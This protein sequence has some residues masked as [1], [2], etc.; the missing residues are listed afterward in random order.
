MAPDWPTYD[1]LV[2]HFSGGIRGI[3]HF[4]DNHLYFLPVIRK[5][6]RPQQSLERFSDI[7]HLPGYGTI[8]G[9]DFYITIDQIQNLYPPIWESFSYNHGNGFL[10]HSI[11]KK[12]SDIQNAA[13]RKEMYSFYDT[14]DKISAWTDATARSLRSASEGYNKVLTTVCAK[15][16]FMQDKAFEDMNYDLIIDSL[17]SFLYHAGTLRDHI[18]E[19]IVLHIGHGFDRDT[20]KKP[21]M[22]KLISQLEKNNSD[23]GIGN[24]KQY[25]LDSNNI[26][27]KAEI[28]PGW[29][30][31]LS[32]YRNIITHEKSLDKIVCRN[33]MWMRLRQTELWEIPIIHFPIPSIPIV[34]CDYFKNSPNIPF[35]KL[36]RVGASH[37]FMLNNPDGLEVMW[38]IFIQLLLLIEKVLQQSPLPPEPIR[39]D[40]TNSRVIKVT[41]T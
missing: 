13:Y 37:D 19:F 29:L 30:C 17:H 6:H 18:A 4:G 15:N 9:M 11:K 2:V 8:Y 35:E 27:A 21:R 41:Y 34:N 31:K 7:F 40:R 38:Q 3:N 14:L 36:Q 20:R 24:I 10:Y 1:R 39:L 12:I 5:E 28:M 16:E 32:N 23:F 25:I 26:N 22:P 33:W